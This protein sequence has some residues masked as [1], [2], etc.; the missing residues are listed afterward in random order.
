MRRLAHLVSLP[1]A[2][3][4]GVAGPAGIT[5]EYRCG[6]PPDVVKSKAKVQGEAQCKTKGKAKANKGTR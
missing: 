5:T 4:G 1:D 3:V 6:Q 2:L